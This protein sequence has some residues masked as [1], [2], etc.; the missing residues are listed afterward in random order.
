MLPNASDDC[1][2]LISKLLQFDPDK[3]IEVKQIL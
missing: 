3:R 1:I 2:D